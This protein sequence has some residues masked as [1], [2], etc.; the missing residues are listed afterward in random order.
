[1]ETYQR[2]VVNGSTFS[3]TSM[4]RSKLKNSHT[5][6]Y[7]DVKGQIQF[8]EIKRFLVLGRYHFAVVTKQDQSE[9]LSST[10]TSSKLLNNICNIQ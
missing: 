1:M 3:C 10:I 6:Q 2:V 5:A 7:E 8:R 4:A 9:S